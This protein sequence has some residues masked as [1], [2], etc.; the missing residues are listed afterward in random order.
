MSRKKGGI[1][2]DRQGEMNDWTF[3]G[4]GPSKMEEKTSK[5]PLVENKKWQYASRLFGMNTLKDGAM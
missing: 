4:F 1:Q 3:G 2:Q 5:T